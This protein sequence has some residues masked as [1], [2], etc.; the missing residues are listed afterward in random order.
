M[1]RDKPHPASAL[2]WTIKAISNKLYNDN[3]T[4]TAIYYNCNE[5]EH[6]QLIPIKLNHYNQSITTTINCEPT[7]NSTNSHQPL[8]PCHAIC[9]FT[10]NKESNAD[11]T[12]HI[13]VQVNSGA[14]QSITNLKDHLICFVPITNH[15]IY[16]VEKEA[17]ALN[18]TGKGYLQW[19]A[20]TDK[21]GKSLTFQSLTAPMQQKLLYLPQMLSCHTSKHIPHGHNLPTYT[22]R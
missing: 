22:H 20:Q 1:Q 17:V 14:N 13:K 21:L 6:T 19:V 3:S 15:P 5:S 9:F 2:P 8:L 10:H 7:S 18:C 11:N 4:Y 12:Y 16:G